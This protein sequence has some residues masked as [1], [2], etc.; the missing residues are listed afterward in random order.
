M[1]NDNEKGGNYGMLMIMTKLILA[2]MMMTKIIMTMMMMIM[3]DT[4]KGDKYD[5]GND[6]DDYV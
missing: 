4:V 6:D 3:F 5:D 2:M 1:M